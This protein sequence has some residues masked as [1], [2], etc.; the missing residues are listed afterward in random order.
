VPEPD[1]PVI[2]SRLV[3]GL[4]AAIAMAFQ[5]HFIYQTLAGEQFLD[6]MAFFSYALAFSHDGR[7]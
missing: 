7:N 5:F 6:A 1:A 2:C 4:S 3:P